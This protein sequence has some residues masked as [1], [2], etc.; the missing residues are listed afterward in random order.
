MYF[1]SPVSLCMLLHRL[2]FMDYIGTKFYTDNDCIPRFIV[3]RNFHVQKCQN[4]I[5]QLTGCKI[6]W[7]RVLWSLQSAGF[8]LVFSVVALLS[9]SSKNNE[10]GC[11][12]NS[13]SSPTFRSRHRTLKTKLIGELIVTYPWKIRFNQRMDIKEVLEQCIWSDFFV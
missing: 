12:I 8:V 11:I 4:V 5:S 7:N 3:L 1:V 9:T 6:S 2:K 10:S 13:I